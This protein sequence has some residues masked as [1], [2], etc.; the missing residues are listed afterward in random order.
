M[1]QR[2]MPVRNLSQ[3][4]DAAA[5]ALMKA[6]PQYLDSEH[7]SFDQVKA[8]CDKLVARP[9]QPERRDTG[10]PAPAAEAPRRKSKVDSV[11]APS[12]ARAAPKAD[13]V[14]VSRFSQQRGSVPAP[15]SRALLDEVADTLSSP[16]SLGSPGAGVIKDDLGLSDDDA[17][18]AEDKALSAFASGALSSARTASRCNGTQRNTASRPLGSSDPSTSGDEGA[19]GEAPG[20]AAKKGKGTKKAAKKAKKGGEGGGRSKP[21]ARDQASLESLL[22]MSSDEDAPPAPSFASK[23]D[24]SPMGSFGAPD[25]APARSSMSSLSDMPSLGSRRSAPGMSSLADMPPL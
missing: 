20:K 15:L 6:H 3:G 22:G 1:R 11:A 21:P 14:P 25:K 7:V 2:L 13:A 9:A 24:E 12:A 16:G 18:A 8:L 5:Q 10:Q 19:K 17:A 4:T 23:R